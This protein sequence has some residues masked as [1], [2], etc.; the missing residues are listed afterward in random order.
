[1]RIVYYDESGDDG[2]PQYSSPLFC[3]TAVYMHYLSWKENYEAILDF[4]RKL[5]S[6]FNFPVKTEMHTKYFLLDKNPYREFK[7]SGEDKKQIINLYCQLISRLDIKVI[8][9]VMVKDKLKRSNFDVLDTALTYSIQRIENDLNSGNNPDDRFMIITDPGRVG[10]MRKTTRRIQRI[11][12]IP[13]RFSTLQYR[14]EIK[15]LIEDPLPKDSKESYFIQISDLISY[16]VYLYSILH[17]DIDELPNRLKTFTVFED[18]KEWLN[19]LKPVFNVKA[20]RSNE[21][22]IVF[23]PK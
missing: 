22:G 4:R 13:S 2:F 15:Y 3:L 23:H 17:F 12:F 7:I 18:I 19:Q 20:A 10:K 6:D 1:M 9:A 14:K 16:I 8:N 5:K 11:N 21:Y